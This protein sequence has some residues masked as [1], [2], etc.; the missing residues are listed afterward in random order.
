M[1]KRHDK[2]P[3]TP[4]Q[5]RRQQTDLLGDYAPDVLLGQ[6]ETHTRRV[7]ESH[8][9]I[10]TVL[11]LEGRYGKGKTYAVQRLFDALASDDPGGYWSPG[12]ISSTAPRSED[13]LMASR[14]RISDP[15]LCNPA[16]TPSWFWIGVPCGAASS[17]NILGDP[18]LGAFHWQLEQHI[19]LLT[20]R[21]G[22][23]RA[24]G[25][26]MS[27]ITGEIAEA[28]SEHL[29]D[30]LAGAVPLGT[31]A[32]TL[33]RLA[34][35]VLKA[36]EEART[37]VDEVDNARARQAYDQILKFVDRASAAG[38]TT[39]V[40]L[41]DAHRCSAN[42]LRFL[43]LA[44]T[45]R[46]AGAPNHYFEPQIPAAARRRLVVLATAWPRRETQGE[47]WAWQRELAMT[48]VHVETFAETSGWLPGLEKEKAIS[49]LAKF[50]PN[51]AIELVE[52]IV[53]AGSRDGQINP[54]LLMRY[55]TFAI[56]G[57]VDER[58]DLDEWLHA[59]PTSLE[60]IQRRRFDV[61]SPPAQDA[62][63]IAAYFGMV[64]PSQALSLALSA[65][66]PEMA[67]PGS[68]I[69][70]LIKRHYLAVAGN[71]RILSEPPSPFEELT[72]TD[73]ADLAW[74]R[75]EN[76]RFQWLRRVVEA[77]LVHWYE[78][79]LRFLSHDLDTD[80]PR[81]RLDQ[82]LAVVHP[83]LVLYGSHGVRKRSLDLFTAAVSRLMGDRSTIRAVNVE[84]ADEN[85]FAFVFAAASQVSKLDRRCLSRAWSI[86]K[87][88]FP[89]S[90][91]TVA[92]AVYV[93]S[94]REFAE[95]LQAAKAILFAN[96]HYYPSA[97][98]LVRL[99]GYEDVE[100]AREILECVVDDPR[101]VIQLSRLIRNETPDKAVEML[102]GAADDPNVAIE[103]SRFIRQE[104]PERAREVLEAVEA[105][106]RVAVELSWLIR[107]EQPARAREI[108]EGLADHPK[109]AIELSRL[110]RYEHPEKAR[111]V[112]ER[113][114]NDPSAAIEL[115]HLIRNEQPEKAREVLEH[116]ANDAPA[117]IELA[118]L[119]RSKQPAKAREILESFAA[120][121]ESA[122]MELAELI[123]D[124]EPERAQ[125][126]LQRFAE[127]PRAAIQLSRLLRDKQP[128]KAR[129]ILEHMGK[130]PY[131]AIAL[132]RLIRNEQPAK[133]REIL[134]RVA[135]EPAA[136]IEL[137]RL[138]R[139]DE[140][141]K[142]R[143]ILERAASDPAAAIE[144]SRLIRKEQ[145]DKARQ[146][147]EHVAKDPAA[148]I[149][150]SRLIR[151]E[152][153]ARAR[154]ILERVAKDPSAAIELSRLIRSEEP[155]KSREVLEPVASDDEHAAIELSRLIRIEQPEKARQILERL[156]H[157]ED[158]AIELSRLIRESEP[159]ESSKVLEHL[160]V[161]PKVAI[162]SAIQLSRRGKFDEAFNVLVRPAC[163]D[164][165]A[166]LLLVR[167]AVGDAKLATAQSILTS[168]L[169]KKES[170]RFIF[171][172][173]S[174]RLWS[175]E[176]VLRALPRS[177]Y[178]L[179][180]FLEFLRRKANSDPHAAALYACLARDVFPEFGIRAKAGLLRY[181]EMNAFCAVEVSSFPLSK[182]EAETVIASLL[183]HAAAGD[184]RSVFAAARLASDSEDYQSLKQAIELLELRHEFTEEERRTYETVA[185]LPKLEFP[186]SRE[187][188]SPWSVTTVWT[189]RRR[190][191]DASASK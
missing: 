60:D 176:A 130:N 48:G 68:V 152:Q 44:L 175:S 53:H 8:D 5:T 90:R 182:T 41:D 85:A 26:H 115:S 55:A 33:F 141:E 35:E 174:K 168:H 25:Q 30:H 179:D 167:N 73:E 29:V 21:A 47:F 16:S 177:S 91:S 28:A 40:V 67:V 95:E 56:E 9:P 54:L 57:E 82:Q 186:E 190:S 125:D 139:S 150:L 124:K 132:S 157:N 11:I 184:R 108:L 70:E 97:I 58:I 96:R 153:P 145:G 142:A 161:T 117:A 37:A 189:A 104:Q 31:I 135:K 17:A 6:L 187:I 140:P 188:R 100:G 180:E 133:A 114:A 49:T 51:L 131:A 146:I 84:D 86:A 144:L 93:A 170:R 79:V 113:V 1:T 134:E 148:A 81:V 10:P 77:S 159:D 64:L 118:R 143:E 7:I 89:H 136:A 154:E 66:H 43:A 42:T 32:L 120:K 74:L 173:L 99:N 101:A 88:S 127:Y 36:V 14:K 178:R 52:K 27:K 34:K 98:R 121:N 137:S 12:L 4:D 18:L 61:L 156:A 63:R 2:N 80:V 169:D 116:V 76:R 181:T 69:A 103:L 46:E 111:E 38:I 24:V 162:E 171:D 110:I 123:Q 106:P 22:A 151:A 50:L 112:L 75:V 107:T 59:L 19:R 119:I 160:A 20:I 15:A 39:I 87:T 72:F 109:V 65:K 78:E 3:A 164:G 62:A 155:L 172:N 163:E 147:L 105:V 13:E 126:I 92:M 183:R 122:A 158:A 149:E 129:E 191:G 166:A 185:P 138:I 45:G 128:E 23:T 83:S 102:E 165:T 71:E 94:R